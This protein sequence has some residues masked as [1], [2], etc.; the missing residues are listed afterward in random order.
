MKRLMVAAPHSGSGKTTFSMGLM[1]ALVRR[2]LAVQPGKV[3]PD[4]ID[5]AHHERICGRRAVNLDAWLLPRTVC[6][7]LFV[8]R[9]ADA[10]ITVVEGVMGLYDGMGDDS[11]CS[12]AEMA[13]W[14][15]VPVVLVVDASGM[16]ASAA[17][18]VKGF[19]LYDPAVPIAGVVFNRVYGE[20]HYAL[21]RGAVERDCGVR[22]YG[23]LPP[24]E[25]IGIPSRHLGLLPAAELADAA[26]RD[27]RL[28]A[29][30]EE[31][32]DVAGLLALAEQPVARL[33]EPA[34]SS[35]APAPFPPSGESAR[36]E[37]FV[38]GTETEGDAG[39]PVRIAIAWDKAF[40]FYY[41][42]GLAVLA[43]MGAELVR[44]S[45]LLDA[46]LPDCDGVYIGGGFPEMFA[47]E[48]EANASMRRSVHRAAAAGLPIYGECG[49]Y[50]Y[51]SE[52]IVNAGGQ[53]HAMC[54]VLPGTA[55]MKA[56]L[57]GQFGYVEVF[58]PVATILGPAGM[59]WHAH[60]FHH[61]AMEGESGLQTIR[62]AAGTLSWQGGAMV[63]NTLGTYA[64]VH[65][66]GEPELAAS[67]LRHCR[68]GKSGRG[69]NG[70]ACSGRTPET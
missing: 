19:C 30:L 37:P 32:V 8:R 34:G 25:D 1:A 4:Y 16:A 40:H 58:Q 48:L 17:A 24:A 52:G 29:R 61:S 3:G 47:T 70:Q 36:P 50:M 63:G 60:E 56:K 9:S 57:S 55:V 67:F 62:K 7:T 10:D 42:D 66:A 41:E 49:G 38:C 12:T 69:C 13:K 2:G 6:E 43:S 20:R 5:T 33:D 68:A 46:E 14:L 31:T 64:H 21:L 22:C 35:P 18:L 65:F 28:A 59:A 53:R 54:G 44:F 26:A 15:G 45:P 27:E 51:L 39:V 23:Y 11:A